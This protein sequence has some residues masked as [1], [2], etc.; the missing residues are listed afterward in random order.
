MRRVV[1]FWGLLL[2]GCVGGPVLTPRT[3]EPDRVLLF[4][5]RRAAPELEP[6]WQSWSLYDSGRWVYARAGADPVK[7]RLVVARLVAVR[8]WLRQ[9]DFELTRESAAP[10]EPA[11]GGLTGSCQLRLSTGLVLA[12]PGDRR[13]Y[14]CQELRRLVE[15]D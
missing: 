5:E 9:H 7:Q 3:V 10:S 12:A 6:T 8:A 11:H 13:F 15:A 14:A 4:E 1:A 2:G